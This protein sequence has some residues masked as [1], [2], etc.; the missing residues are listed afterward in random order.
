MEAALAVPGV[1]AVTID[2]PPHTHGTLALAAIE[3]GKHVL[4][5]KPF[6]RDADEARAL[7]HSTGIDRAP[8]TRMAETFRDLILGRPVPP[9]P[10][11]A[12][13]ADGV[14]LMEVMDAIRASADD[15]S[16]WTLT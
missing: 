9:D 11:P 2:T 1:D 16:R 8:F 6:A 14:A 10:A 7:L 3:A 12:T 5:E 15:Q 13:F 4:C